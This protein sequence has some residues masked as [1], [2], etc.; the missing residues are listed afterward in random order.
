MYSAHVQWYATYSYLWRVQVNTRRTLC[1]SLIK[2]VRS[3][4]S[5]RIPNSTS[6][7][8]S[9]HTFREISR[10]LISQLSHRRLAL[11]GIP[12]QRLAHQSESTV[13]GA[14]SCTTASPSPAPVGGRASCHPTRTHRNRNCL[15]G[16]PADDADLD[17]AVASEAIFEVV[18]RT[19]HL[20]SIRFTA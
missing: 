9:R 12:P 16:L 8:P 1:A 11:R 7:R 18:L 2:R 4:P 5:H 6:S 14:R 19:C 13:S 17:L 20:I 3:Q 10:P 15:S